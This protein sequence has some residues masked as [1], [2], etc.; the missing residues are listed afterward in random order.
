MKLSEL[1]TDLAQAVRQRVSAQ[2]EFEFLE[3]IC[4][5]H[6]LAGPQ[7]IASGEKAQIERWYNN[8]INNERKADLARQNME[9]A[10]LRRKVPEILY[11]HLRR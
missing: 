6:Q 1:F 2:R 8:Q 4:Y 11:R 9:A 3:T 5:N 7:I 10:S